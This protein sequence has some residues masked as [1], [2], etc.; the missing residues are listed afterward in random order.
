MAKRLTKSLNAKGQRSRCPINLTLEAIGDAW[1]LLIVRDLIFRGAQ[2]YKELLEGG[3]GIATN[4]LADR[5]ARLQACGI[6][7]SERD[8]N[9]ARRLQ[10][11]LTEKGL[12][13]A[14]LL[15]EM[16]LWGAEHGESDAP[17]E[18]LEVIRSDRKK[19]LKQVRAQSSAAGRMTRMKR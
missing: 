14:P 13:L 12:G 17:A 5:L 9:D 4:I 19:F 10:Y 6:L 1:S 8:P 7:E 16:I 3:E 15:V 18:M 11:T 2:T